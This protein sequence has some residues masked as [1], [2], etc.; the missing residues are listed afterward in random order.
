MM[1]QSGRGT[2]SLKRIIRLMQE[3]G[4]GRESESA[5]GLRPK[6]I[7]IQVIAA[8]RLRPAAA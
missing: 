6:A 5:A 1:S 3:H 7:R 2:V 4:L 8:D